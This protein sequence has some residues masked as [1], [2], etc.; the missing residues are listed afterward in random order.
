MPEYC[1]TSKE[2]WH[3]FITVEAEDID[4]ALHQADNG[5]GDTG[6]GEYS[7]T[8][9]YVSIR[10]EDTG[11]DTNLT[12]SAMEEMEESDPNSIF[13]KSKKQKEVDKAIKI[14]SG[15][16]ITVKSLEKVLEIL[17]GIKNI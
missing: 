13:S 10:N 17:K 6:D 3:S 1:I 11:E 8:I 12:M 15:K 16:Y 5:D 2:V 7:H 9:G 4:A 14:I